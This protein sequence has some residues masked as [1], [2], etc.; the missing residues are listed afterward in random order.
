MVPPREATAC[1]CR[2]LVAVT[3]R[4]AAGPFGA[5]EEEAEEE[6]LVGVGAGMSEAGAKRWMSIWSSAGS[7]ERM[8]RREAR[9]SPTSKRR[10]NCSIL[11]GRMGRREQ[12]I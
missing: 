9:P 12:C 6:E 11:R 7:T 8:R 4:P 2:A 10:M 5:T 3:G 1:S